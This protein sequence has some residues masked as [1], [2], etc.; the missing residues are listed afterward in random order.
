MA[1]AA[2]DRTGRIVSVGMSAEQMPAGDG[3]ALKEI[4]DDVALAV[5][6]G[7]RNMQSC[8][9]DIQP[10]PQPL[11]TRINTNRW[12]KRYPS[13]MNEVDAAAISQLAGLIAPNGVAVEVGS[14]LGGT[15]KNI[16]DHAP[17][18]KRLYCIDPEWGMAQGNG[19]SDP[20][21]YNLVTDWQLDGYASCRQFAEQMLQPYANVRLLSMASP[22]DLAWWNEPVDFF[23]EDATHYNPVLSDNLAFWVPLVKQGGIIAGHDYNYHWP[24]VEREV[25]QLRDKLGA[26]LHVQGSVWWMHKP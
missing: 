4:A 26:E 14:R 13:M 16:L 21:L 15:A 20:A 22:Y 10:P 19:M 23:F 6:H 9:G 3:I 25:D 1:W 17:S 12:T 24:E 8:L 11:Q 7:E 18:I 5:M 2:Q